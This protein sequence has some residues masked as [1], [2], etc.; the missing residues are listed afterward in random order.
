MTLDAYQDILQHLGTAAWILLHPR[1]QA[2]TPD[3]GLA[4][5]ASFE[6]ARL[7]LRQVVYELERQAERAFGWDATRA[8]LSTVSAT[9]RYLTT[10]GRSRPTQRPPRT[11]PVMPVVTV[12]N[13]GSLW[14]FWAHTPDARDWF[15]DNTDAMP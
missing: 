10:Q 14:L 5:D 6:M 12:E 9:L 8:A 2:D 11:E 15:T 3:A 4:V 13:H 1:R 7:A